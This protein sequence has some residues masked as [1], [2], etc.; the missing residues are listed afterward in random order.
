M[1]ISDLLYAP[2]PLNA[3]TVE[4]TSKYRQLGRGIVALLKGISF[5]HCIVKGIRRCPLK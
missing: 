1:S 2:L 4:V 3:L 5:L